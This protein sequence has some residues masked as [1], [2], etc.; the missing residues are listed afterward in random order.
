MSTFNY[1]EPIKVV[2]DILVSQLGLTESQVV[3]SNEKW[4]IPTVG[5]LVVLSYLTSVTLNS[6]DTWVD[7]GAGLQ[8]VQTVTLFDTIQVQVLGFKTPTIRALRTLIPMAFN[9]LLAQGQCELWN[10]S[11][12]VNP[13]PMQDTSYLE[14][15]EMITRYTVPIN[16]TS[17]N[18]KLQTVPD[19]YTDFSK[20]I[21]P[22]VVVNA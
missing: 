5:P 1:R 13:G 22:Q 15:T 12:A 16:V 7:Q 14:G 17:I 8:E 3:F 20:A 10:M 11:I 9:S 21:P 4:N 6:T 2:R 18:Q 19:I